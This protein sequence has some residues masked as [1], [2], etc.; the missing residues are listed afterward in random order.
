LHDGDETMIV[1]LLACYGI[2]GCA[3]VL[4][5]PVRLQ[6]EH[7]VAKMRG[8]PLAN[9]MTGREPVSEGRLLGFRVAV[10]LGAAV[11]WPVTLVSVL[12][13]QSREA[14]EQKNWE[15]RVA[16]GLEFSR[17]GGAGEIDC[18]D[19]GFR[20]NFT[21]FLH[22]YSSDGER[23]CDAG[24]QCLSCGRLQ[25]VHGEGDPAQYSVTRCE[26]GGQLSRDHI[27]FCPQC[28]SKSLHYRMEMI[29]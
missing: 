24:W 11:M 3:I 16:G 4:V 25:T 26:C 28:K 8:S 21:S 9:T 29:T 5:G 19:C 2:I 13:T 23:C 20:Q 10:S 6:I 1:H 27:L 18:H 7:E 17:I 14:D 22:G 15:R 12:R